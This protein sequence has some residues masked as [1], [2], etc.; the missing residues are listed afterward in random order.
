M[1]LIV[2]SKSQSSNND[3][4]CLLPPNWK[5]SVTSWLEEDIP[6]F[7]IGG[8]V[9]GEKEEVAHLFC[10]SRGMVAGLPFVTA[11]MESVDC[12]FESFVKD[13]DFLDPFKF[14]DQKI[15]IGKVKGKCRNILL[16]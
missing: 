1:S 2:T 10:K 13:G 8:F 9:V 16:G 5:S 11:I 14:N 15:C 7:D 4:S 6:S 12:A 3:F